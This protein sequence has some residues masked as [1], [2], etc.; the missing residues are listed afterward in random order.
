MSTTTVTPELEYEVRILQKRHSPYMEYPSHVHLETMAYC[1]AA[2]G[3][4]PYPQLERKGARMSDALIDKVINELTEI[5]HSLPFQISPFKVSEP[6]LD[7]RLFN[8]L[9]QIN[10]KL[11]SAS[12]SLTTN[13]T[14]LTE[15]KL[16]ALAHVNNVAYLWI[17]FNDHRENEYEQTMRLN[18]R[19]T[20]DRLDLI[21]QWKA[22]G[23]FTFPV[24]LSRVGDGSAI[25]RDFCAWVSE[26]YPSFEATVFRRGNWL[27][28][29]DA[30]QEKVPNIGCLRWFELS[31]T[32]TGKVAHCCMDGQAEFPIGD[33][34]QQHVLKIYNS[35]HYRRLRE[36][37]VSRLHVAPC[38]RC[39]FR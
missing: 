17:S 37:T 3:F 28:Q 20:R 1:N 39:T 38:N 26:K 18:Y 4:C 11:P 21:H 10:R 27:G 22:S 19:R 36:Q 34:T 9:Q 14:P 23:R 6:F 35:P 29:V 32:A 5:P 25:D 12:I 33:V 16:N 8:I 13:A 15:K 31:I 30:Q 2:C 24:V 7:K